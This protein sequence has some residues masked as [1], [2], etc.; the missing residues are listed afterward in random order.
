MISGLEPGYGESSEYPSQ[1][2][3]EDYFALGI[4]YYSNWILLQSGR[5]VLF[6]SNN[7]FISEDRTNIN[8]F[9]YRT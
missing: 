8:D 6:I 9:R 7:S 2:F 1:F 5:K 3:K 4:T